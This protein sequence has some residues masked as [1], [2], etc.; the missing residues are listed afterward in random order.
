MC[1]GIGVIRIDRL[2]GRYGVDVVPR[3]HV[4]KD[5]QSLRRNH[6]ESARGGEKED[7]GGHRAGNLSSSQI[8]QGSSLGVG[9]VICSRSPW[10]LVA[11]CLPH[12]LLTEGK[13]LQPCGISLG[14]PLSVWRSLCVECSDHFA[15]LSSELSFSQA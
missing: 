15:T 1:D 12:K 14:A 13:N 2:E 6:P 10:Q 3:G 9:V 5:G 7:Q 8:I 4:F 11:I